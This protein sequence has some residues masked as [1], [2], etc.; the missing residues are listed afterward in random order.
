MIDVVRDLR[1]DSGLAQELYNFRYRVFVEHAGWQLPSRH[2]LEMDQFDTPQA[3]HLV[4]RS[5]D[6]SI[7]GLLRLLPTTTPYMIERLW[8]DLLAG[9]PPPRSPRI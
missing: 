9:T 2:Q 1:A 6:G 5:Q 8:S 4:S 7:A 3:I